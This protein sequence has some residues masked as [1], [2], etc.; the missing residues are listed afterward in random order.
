MSEHRVV[1]REEWIRERCE[2]LAEENRWLKSSLS[3]AISPL[4]EK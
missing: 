3:K 1:S 2:L 4:I